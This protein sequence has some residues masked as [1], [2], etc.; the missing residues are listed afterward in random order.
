M[1]ANLLLHLKLLPLLRNCL[2]LFTMVHNEIWS[3]LELP[4][5]ALLEHPTTQQEATILPTLFIA[6]QD[7]VQGAPPFII[8]IRAQ[9]YCPDFASVDLLALRFHSRFSTKPFPS[10]P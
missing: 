6:N 10:F 9:L 4:F 1:D 8:Y 2:N 5:F 3:P 7:G